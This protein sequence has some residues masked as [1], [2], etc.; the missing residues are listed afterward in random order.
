MPKGREILFNKFD[1]KNMQIMGKSNFYTWTLTVAFLL[2]GLFGF[3]ELVSQAA[4]AR[5]PRAQAGT[6]Q[7]TGEIQFQ[8]TK[9]HLRAINMA[10]DPECV[11]ENQG[12]EVYVQDGAVNPNNT[13]PNAFVYVKSGA[14]QSQPPAQPVTLDQQ[15][16]IYVPHVLGIMVGQTLKVVNSDFTTHNIHVMAK[17]NPQWN[18]SQPPG[19]APINN[20][21]DN[22][23]IMVPVECNEHRWMK[24]YIGVVANPFYDVSDTQGKFMIKG[25]PAGTYTIETWTATFG[26]QEKTVT[27]RPNETAT[28]D[29][30]FKNQ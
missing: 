17:N 23:E 20:K 5:N 25:L 21:F 30:T 1:V 3:G 4:P 29:F 10:N 11:E 22:P 26:T 27:L 28:L 8:G 15:G 2:F 18:T 14:P 19:A 7:I 16:C 24:A 6:G 13:L 12:R 9:P